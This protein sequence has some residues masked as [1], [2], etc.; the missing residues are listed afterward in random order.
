MDKW[1]L[2][3]ILMELNTVI[4]FL[5]PIILLRPF[6]C[7]EA[8]RILKTDFNSKRIRVTGHGDFSSYNY[9]KSYKLCVSVFESY[10]LEIRKSDSIL[11]SNRLEGHEQ[12]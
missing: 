5:W 3:I 1:C 12:F 10:F 11:V 4:R 7:A 6:R 9:R 8:I 2:T